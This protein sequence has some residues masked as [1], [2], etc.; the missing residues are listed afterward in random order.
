MNEVEKFLV[1]LF[2]LA[3]FTYFCGFKDYRC[4]CRSGGLLGLPVKS[5]I[6]ERMSDSWIGKSN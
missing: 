2:N 3:Y 5:G 6:R 4:K 1:F